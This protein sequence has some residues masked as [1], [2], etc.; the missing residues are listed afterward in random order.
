MEKEY[1]IKRKTLIKIAILLLLFILIIILLSS[2]SYK[3]V[4]EPTNKQ[5]YNYIKDFNK[6]LKYLDT[7]N[8]NNKFY[9]IKSSYENPLLL[10]CSPSTTSY[11]SIK[12]KSYNSYLLLK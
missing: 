6:S 12:G 3:R 7:T 8:G 4:N 2:N 1:V 10:D 5:K 11:C 9:I